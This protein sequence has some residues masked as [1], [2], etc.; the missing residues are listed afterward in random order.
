MA[1]STRLAKSF[2]FA[3]PD[4]CPDPD[5]LLRLFIHESARVI[6]DSIEP[7]HRSIFSKDIEK[8]I[9]ENFTTTQQAV[10]KHIAQ[11]GENEEDEDDSKDAI[12]IDMFDLIYSEVDAHD[13]VDGLSYEPVIDRV[14]FQ[15]SIENFLFEH[16]RNHPKD[17]IR[18]FIDW[19]TSGWVQRVMRVIRQASEHMVLSAPPSS[20]RTQVVKAACVA[21]NAMVSRVTGLG[22]PGLGLQASG[23]WASGFR[24]FRL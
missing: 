7:T 13:V 9:D 14:Q 2:F 10:L 24:A 3:F 17:R 21:C 12:S 1:L 5:A 4:N 8:L 22:L 15:R 23:F 11:L 20:G 16:H 19:E 18:L 6:G